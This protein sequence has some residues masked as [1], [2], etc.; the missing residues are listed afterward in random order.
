MLNTI[1]IKVKN[2]FSKK[3]NSKKIKRTKMK[4]PKNKKIIN[5]HKDNIYP[6]SSNCFWFLCSKIY[7]GPFP[8]KFK[9]LILQINYYVQGEYPFH[10]AI[11]FQ[12][13]FQ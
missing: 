6:L 2:K 9:R 7:T 4:K 3:N 11:F 13:I 1:K 10:E 5:P 12:F 8:G